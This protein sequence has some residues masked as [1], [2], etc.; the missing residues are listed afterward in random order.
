MIAIRLLKMQ[1]VG[2][3]SG[4][5]VGAKKFR[6]LPPGPWRKGILGIKTNLGE[7]PAYVIYKS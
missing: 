6:E 2:F 5:G 7:Q 1:L 3:F 4:M